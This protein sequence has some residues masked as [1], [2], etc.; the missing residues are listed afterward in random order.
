MLAQERDV[1]KDFLNILK[2]QQKNIFTNRKGTRR[3]VEQLD[4]YKV[5]SFDRLR[6]NSTFN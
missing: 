5:S 1:W 3:Y 6:S 4:T 2:D